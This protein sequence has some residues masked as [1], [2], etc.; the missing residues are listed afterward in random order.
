MTAAAEQRAPEPDGG[1]WR[2]ADPEAGG[3]VFV[4]PSCWPAVEEYWLARADATVR[5]L[6]PRPAWA[7]CGVCDPERVC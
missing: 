3:P 5:V 1:G 2:V 7:R 4:W 6:G